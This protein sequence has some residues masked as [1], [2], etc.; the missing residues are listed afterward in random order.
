MLRGASE[1]NLKEKV[2]SHMSGALGSRLGSAGLVVGA[3]VALLAGSSGVAAAKEDLG[4]CIYYAPGEAD[5]PTKCPYWRVLDKNLSGRDFTGADLR[6]AQFDGANL[7]GTN[8]TNAN[9]TGV[10]AK[11]PTWS[12]QTQ[13]GG[14]LVDRMTTLQGLV[15]EQKVSPLSGAG[16][17]RYFI[18][19][20]VNPGISSRYRPRAIPQGVSID[21]CKSS[22]ASTVQAVV[23]G[24]QVDL[25]V[26][27]PGRHIVTCWFST[28]GQP[29]NK[30][31]TAF[32]V[33][34]SGNAPMIPAHS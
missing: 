15:G 19:D 23:N 13:L 24:Q 26:L 4:G 30:G 32:V 14:A 10:Q 9:L 1:R 27:F 25:K 16:A 18:V 29:N 33:N 34:V 5:G 20:G 6:R 8:F 7:G 22:S 12:P 11:D 17:N 28:A 3:V 2:R 21:E 31:A